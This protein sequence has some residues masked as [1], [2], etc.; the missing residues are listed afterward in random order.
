MVTSSVKLTGELSQAHAE[1]IA[2]QEQQNE[3]VA[4]YN[5]VACDNEELRRKIKTLIDNNQEVVVKFEQALEQN[6]LLTTTNQSMEEASV[7]VDKQHITSK[8]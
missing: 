5:Q 3:G 4:K 2:L 7:D 1:V 6:L 8:K